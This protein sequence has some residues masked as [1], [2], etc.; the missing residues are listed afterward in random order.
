MAEIINAEETQR[1][2]EQTQ[3]DIRRVL[4]SLRGLSD[5]TLWR[6]LKTLAYSAS[7]HPEISAHPFDLETHF[8]IEHHDSQK[9]R[10]PVN[11]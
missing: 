2:L 3:A 9:L 6:F 11:P 10:E 4:A 8:V 1:N 5:P 7:Q